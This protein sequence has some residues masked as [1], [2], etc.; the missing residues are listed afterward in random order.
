MDETNFGERLYVAMI[1]PVTILIFVTNL[2][3]GTELFTAGIAS[4]LGGMV[5]PI[6]ILFYFVWLGAL[7]Q[8]FGL[9]LGCI[10]AI[11]VVGIIGYML[12]LSGKCLIDLFK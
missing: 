7:Y 10:G 12:Y 1:L 2:F 6:G 11:A 5:W 9:V 4:L 8:P 3:V